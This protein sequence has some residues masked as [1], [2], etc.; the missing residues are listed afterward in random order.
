MFD[1]NGRVAV[2]IGATSGI[3]RALALGLA[4]QGATVVP[5]GRRSL[6]LSSV[7]EEIAALGRE[8][9]HVTSDVRDRASLECLRDA[10][11]AKFHRVDILLNAA[12][13]TFRQPSATVTDEQWSTLMDTNITGVLRACR[14]FYR[15]LRDSGSGR[16]I[17]IASLGAYV[18]FQ[19]VAAYS[20]SKA[21]VLS[22][23]KSLAV[24]WAKDGICVNA[25]AP[26][27]IVSDLN[28][29]LV[30]GT[31]RGE[32]IL[33]RTPMARFGC[34]EELVEAAV[35]LASPSSTFLTGQCIA[36]DG[37]YLASGVNR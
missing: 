5:S 15:P 29:E 18:A 1:L 35:L 17:N 25:I 6:E 31:S 33:I 10:I 12:G 3:G 27:V 14:S 9:L 4:R 37:G 36:V 30:N 2:C 32:E 34:A 26:G 20:A 24:E 13:Y 23:T 19:E 8:T 16:I 28:C 21:A 7:C 22:L 11:L